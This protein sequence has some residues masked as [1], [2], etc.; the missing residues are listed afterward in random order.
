MKIKIYF[1]ICFLFG[2]LC[3][4][5]GDFS[6]RIVKWDMGETQVELPLLHRLSF[7]GDDMVV[8]YYSGVQESYNMENIRKLL[9]KNM[10]GNNVRQ[11]EGNASALQIYPNPVTDYIVLIHLPEGENNV[12]IYSV[13]GN[14]V[15]NVQIDSAG[16]KI[17]VAHLQRGMYILKVN[18]QTAK[19]I[20]Q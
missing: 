15:L 10:V 1:T 17:D 12:S 5:G 16:E 13:S 2:V 3:I 4:R 8:K 18:G 20:K 11:L 14:L 19:F 6:L 9:F 7:S